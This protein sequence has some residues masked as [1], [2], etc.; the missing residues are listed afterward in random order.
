MRDYKR[1]SPRFW[2]E[3][4]AGGWS[5]DMKMLALYLLTCEH[6]TTEGLLPAA[7][8]VHGGRPLGRRRPRLRPRRRLERGARAAGARR[9]LGRRLRPLRPRRPDR[10]PAAGARLPG[11]RE[12]EPAAG[13]GQ[14]RA[15]AARDAAPRGL[16]GGGADLVPEARAGAG[17]TVGRTV[18]RTVGR[19]VGRISSSISSSISRRTH[20]HRRRGPTGSPT[21][22]EDKGEPQTCAAFSGG[23]PSQGRQVRGQAALVTTPGPGPRGL[24]PGQPGTSPS[25]RGA[26]ASSS[27]T[28]PIRRPSSAPSGASRTGRTA[29]RR[30]THPSRSAGRRRVRSSASPA[31]PRSRRRHLRG[32]LHRRPGLAPRTLP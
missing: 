29:R 8:R 28:C 14:E 5:D 1:V 13:R 3:A 22:D 23:L 27:S 24:R 30:G 4:Q 9:A 15:R 10:L 12:P 17:R 2:T 7:G 20:G 31:A 16:H 25:M 32:R 18:D 11:A 26:P 6:R 21:A 19:T